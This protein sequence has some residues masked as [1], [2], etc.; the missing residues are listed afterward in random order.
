MRMGKY[1]TQDCT[2]RNCIYESWCISCYERDMAKVEEL[3]KDDEKLK[4]MMMKKMRIYKYVGET[5]RSVYERTWEHVNSL[6]Q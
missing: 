1:K 6:K 3:S 5:S 2:K 4:A